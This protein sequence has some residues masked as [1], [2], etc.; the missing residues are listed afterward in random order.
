MATEQIKK[1]RK[2][3]AP[4]KLEPE[5][6]HPPDD[7]HPDPNLKPVSEKRKHKKKE[8]RSTIVDFLPHGSL[9]V[10]TKPAP[11]GALLTLVGTFLKSYDFHDTSRI[12][13]TELA[14]RRELDAWKTE[15]RIK[16]P[17]GLPDLVTLYKGWYKGYQRKAKPD[18]KNL[19]KGENQGIGAVPSLR[20]D[21]KKGKRTD[22]RADKTCGGRGNDSN[23]DSSSERSSVESG[24]DKEMEDVTPV[25]PPQKRPTYSS[26]SSNSSLISDSD[27]DDEKEASAQKLSSKKKGE[28]ETSINSKP[29]SSP[30]QSSISE[31]VLRSDP[32]GKKPNNVTKPR[33]TEAVGKTISKN[34]E[35]KKPRKVIKANL[36]SSSSSSSTSSSSESSS[37]EEV[38]SD[39]WA[40]SVT[41]VLPPAESSSS[42]SSSD[43]EAH[44]PSR[45]S[46]PTQKSI[47][48]N[49]TSRLALP[50][51][52]SSTDSSVTLGH[53]S[54]V[55]TSVNTAII[56]PYPSE[57]ADNASLKRRF[58][59][60][61]DDEATIDAVN[62]VKKPR[63]T[64]FKRVPSDTEVDPKL[65]S[66]AYRGHDY[67]DEAHKVLS[68]TR[69]K[70]FTKAKNKKKGSYH[71]GAIDISGGRAIKF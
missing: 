1:K 51:V 17:D 14:F 35:T 61:P 15:M 48:K 22:R 16:P 7:H 28:S 5:Y 54:P 2:K 44:S 31:S 55:K 20:K 25:K 19:V 30:G 24:S 18:V 27:A 11:P 49:K 69:G 62:R 65:A 66:N 71:G 68:V 67:G 8:G 38:A 60:S 41:K 50:T 42:H 29:K 43:E 53:S 39:P 45:A 21:G 56:T 6:G 37:A 9:V 4:N 23:G 70:D 52:K 36:S 46:N 3:N 26:S 33:S 58:P 10:P 12:Y 47:Q 34:A 59:S 40:Q 32:L 64:P 57:K 13:T 63:N